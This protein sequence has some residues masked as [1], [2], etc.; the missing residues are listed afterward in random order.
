MMIE[1][2]A[3]ESFYIDRLFIMICVVNLIY[4]KKNHTVITYII[5]LTYILQLHICDN[6]N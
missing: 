3:D 5:H 1:E 2:D 6:N 4:K